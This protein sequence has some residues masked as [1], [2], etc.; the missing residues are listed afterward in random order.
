MPPAPRPTSMPLGGV[1]PIIGNS[2]EPNAMVDASASKDL[3]APK[4]RKIFFLEMVL[5]PV[6]AAAA[7]IIPIAIRW[8]AFGY[9]PGVIWLAMLI[10]SL[11]S[12][13]WRGL[14]FLLGPPIAILMIVAYL[15]AAPPVPKSKTPSVPASQHAAL[16]E[17]IDGGIIMRSRTDART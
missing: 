4:S 6:V 16:D 15:A 11:I 3:G 8:G 13:R 9:I 1:H 17:S 14:W 12:F 10:Q 7:L 5:S 2:C